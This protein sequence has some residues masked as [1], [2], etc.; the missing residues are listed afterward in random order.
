MD[1]RAAPQLH[2]DANKVR[3]VI[4]RYLGVDI[5]RLTDDVHFRKDFDLDSLDRLELLILIEEEFVGLQ[6][7]DDAI[8]QI[9]VVR[10]L[11]RYMEINCLLGQL[12]ADPFRRSAA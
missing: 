8:T 6:I 7:S 2:F 5:Q 3:A 12:Y 9:E 1:A 10:D 11:I 4:A